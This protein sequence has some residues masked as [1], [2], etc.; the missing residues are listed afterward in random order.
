M[1]SLLQSFSKYSKWPHVRR[2]LHHGLVTA[3]VINTG[4]SRRKVY[5]PVGTQATPVIVEVSEA[6]GL[7]EPTTSQPT[8]N[9]QKAVGEW[10]RTL[11]IDKT[12][13]SRRGVSGHLGAAQS[14]YAV[15]STGSDQHELVLGMAEPLGSGADVFDDVD[16]PHWPSRAP[17]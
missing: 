9:S 10:V 2:G 6:S 17:W 7:S 3:E 16:D 4:I 11:R 14:S 1:H 15:Q 5:R 12:P 8:G 13:C